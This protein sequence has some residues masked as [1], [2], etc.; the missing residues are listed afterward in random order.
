MSLVPRRAKLTCG[1]PCC[2]REDQTPY[3]RF[4]PTAVTAERTWIDLSSRNQFTSAPWGDSNAAS[5]APESDRTSR[6]TD[7]ACLQ[8][9]G[10]RKSVRVGKEC[11][12][13]WSP[14]H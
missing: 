11:R 13:R 2:P 7:A 9:C 5:Q 3:V 4:A 14:Y 6:P 8:P 10:D 12:S 1:G